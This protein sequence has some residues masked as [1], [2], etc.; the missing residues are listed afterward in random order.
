[1]SNV[2]F[3]TFG[4][5]FYFLDDTQMIVTAVHFLLRQV[6]RSVVKKVYLVNFSTYR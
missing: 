4:L 2:I 1:M 6:K 3:F 5:H